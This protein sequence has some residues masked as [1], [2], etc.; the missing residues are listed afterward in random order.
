MLE[1]K[2]LK[3][4]PTREVFPLSLQVLNEALTEEGFAIKNSSNYN[5]K[6]PF[7]D[8]NLDFKKLQSKYSNIKTNWKKYSDRQKN[9]SGLEPEKL[10]KWLNIVNPVLSD[11]NQ[12]LDNITSC[13]EYTSILNAA[14]DR[15]DGKKVAKMMV[16]K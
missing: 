1:T 3:K 6:K 8:L 7:K 11:K 13:P 4:A 10:A 14:E 15:I 16:K 12:G 5:E 2:A 9:G